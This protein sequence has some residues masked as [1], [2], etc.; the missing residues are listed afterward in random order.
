MKLGCPKKTDNLQVS[1][2]NIYKPIDYDNIPPFLSLSTFFLLYFDPLLI[3]SHICLGICPSTRTVKNNSLLELV[4]LVVGGLLVSSHPLVLRY[5]LDQRRV[6]VQHLLDWGRV[7][8]AGGPRTVGVGGT[9][10]G[11]WGPAGSGGRT[12]SWRTAARGTTR[13]TRGSLRGRGGP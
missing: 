6:L 12:P 10:A 13:R 3:F 7:Q 4:D 8:S 2:H 11:W 5:R 9:A 1:L